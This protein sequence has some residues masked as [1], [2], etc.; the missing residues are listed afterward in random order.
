MLFDLR[1]PGRRRF[2]KVIYGGLA[3]LMGGGL[4]FF[5]IGSDATGGLSE[6][7]TGSSSDESGF[8]DQIDDANAALETDPQDAAALAELVQLHY[9][10]GN[11]KLEI[12]EETQQQIFTSEA[13]EDY[14][15]AADAWDRYV[16]ATGGKA[17]PST[18]L[19]AVQNFG[20]LA[21]SEFQKAGTG[22]GQQALDDADASLANWKGAAEA[23]Q[24]V[25]DQR[26]D[27]DSLSSL[28]TLF[29]LAGEFEQADEAKQ[30]ALVA[31]KGGD[32]QQ[33]EQELSAAENQAR[34]LTT[35]IEKFR[36]QIASATQGAGGQG[37]ATGGD[38][39]LSDVG[40]GG[41]ALGGGGLSTP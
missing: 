5:G 24:V 9:Q 15:K 10:A 39:P 16:K 14:T 4:I 29:Y 18:A 3:L 17:D 34:E 25:A 21:Q 1:S 12:D 2:I 31:A 35:A 41:G 8:E 6:L 32:S 13:E 40:G 38:N 26:G 33:I 22:S 30:Q 7:F 11:T 19:L 37:G 23:Q 28:A 20:A 36:K 27:V